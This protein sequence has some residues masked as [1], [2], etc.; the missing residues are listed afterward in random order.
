MTLSS[1]FRDVGEE[2]AFRQAVREA[3]CDLFRPR[4]IDEIFK[5]YGVPESQWV[6]I[7][8]F[9]STRPRLVPVLTEAVS[10][11]QGVFGQ[12]RR[13][14][15]L[16]QDPDGGDEELFCVVLVKGEPEAALQLLCQFD[17]AWFSRN[18]RYVRRHLNFTVDTE[19][20]QRL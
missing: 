20:D 10:Y 1:I 18:T 9:L 6:E 5:L 14:L 13:Y 19:D 3:E 12:A 8:R 16:E 4:E 2:R 7:V 17:D 15:E 11:L